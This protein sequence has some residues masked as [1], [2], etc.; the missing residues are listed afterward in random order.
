MW[1]VLFVYFYACMMFVCLRALFVMF[2]CLHA[3]VMFVMSVCLCA[4]FVCICDVCV[5]A[6][7]HVIYVYAYAC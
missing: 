7:V 4:M 2:V 5:F 3:F 1:N 6:C